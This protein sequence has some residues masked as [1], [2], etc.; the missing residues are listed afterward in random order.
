MATFVLVREADVWLAA[1][2]ASLPA[3]APQGAFALVI[4][5]IGIAAGR[6]TRRG[7]S[8]PLAERVF[9]EGAGI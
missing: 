8:D 9:W 4:L 2:R 7:P 3:S 6:W 5:A 1:A